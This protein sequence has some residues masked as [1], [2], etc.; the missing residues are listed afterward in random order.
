MVDWVNDLLIAT[1]AS[2]I[3]RPLADA[4][5]FAPKEDI[6]PA[7]YRSDII[8]K[9]RASGDAQV[10]KFMWLA[11]LVDS[12]SM[13]AHCRRSGSAR[14]DE[15]L[16]KLPSMYDAFLCGGYSKDEFP[17]CGFLEA[18]LRVYRGH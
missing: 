11:F 14:T 1:D 7:T 6:V 2:V 15:W 10:M 4:F 16:R 12:P 13:Q 5:E 9:V 17:I 3:E 8:H 18:V